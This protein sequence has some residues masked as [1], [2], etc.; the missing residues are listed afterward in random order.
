LHDPDI[1]QDPD[2]F[3]PKRFLNPDGSL[4]N[5]PMLTSEFAFGKRIFPGRH[6]SDAT[7]FIFV[8]SLLSVFK[9]E[10]DRGTD[11]GADAFPY[12]SSGIRYGH[13]GDGKT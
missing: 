1:Y 5:D 13:R 4:R 9:F 8:A 10:K 6:F 11:G 3:K 7:V 2:K 12:I